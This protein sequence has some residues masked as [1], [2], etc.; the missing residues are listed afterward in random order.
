MS[1]AGHLEC[2]PKVNA[3]LGSGKAGHK[4]V[5]F[6][7]YLRFPNSPRSAP[8]EGKRAKEGKRSQKKKKKKNGA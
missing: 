7:E 2:D 5:C 1:Q 6:P 4:T 3:F 8:R